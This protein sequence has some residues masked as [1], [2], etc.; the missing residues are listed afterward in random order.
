MRETTSERRRAIREWSVV[1]DDSSSDSARSNT[2]GGSF[3][4]GSRASSR[5]SASYKGK[6]NSSSRQN[7]Q[8]WETNTDYVASWVRRQPIGPQDIVESQVYNPSEQILSAKTQPLGTSRQDRDYRRKTEQIPDRKSISCS[9]H[10]RK[11]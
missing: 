3:N 4:Y 2:S 6:E 7:S 9:V 5:T 11:G 8:T 10:Q 1:V